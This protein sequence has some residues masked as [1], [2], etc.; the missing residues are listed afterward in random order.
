MTIFDCHS[1]SKNSPDANHSVI[2]MCKSAIE[3]GVSVYTIT[4]HVE[5]YNDFWIQEDPKKTEKIQFKDIFQ[6]SLSDIEKA[7]NIF[8]GKIKLL[9]G[10]ELGEPCQRVKIAEEYLKDKRLDFVIASTHQ[11]RN[12]EDFYFL[13]YSKEN[14]KYLLDTYFDEVLEIAKWNKFDV[15][16]HLTYF[17]RYMTGQQGIVV[18]LN[19]YEEIIREIFKTLAYNGKGIEINTSGYRQEFGDF[20]PSQEYVKMFKECGG[21]IITV[22]SDSHHVDDVAKGIK[23]A[24]KMAKSSGFNY[25]TYFEKRK[26]IINKIDI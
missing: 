20:F 7:K 3:K 11:I 24:L 1:H 17:L 19:P 14:I 22:G 18:D 15:I 4:D 25:V 23:E 5:C 8:D 6:N 16:G 13:D 9:T 21:E 2:D 10:V 12:Y 26:P